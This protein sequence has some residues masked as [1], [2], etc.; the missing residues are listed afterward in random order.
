[1]TRRTPTLLPA[2]LLALCAAMAA[3]ASAFAADA[4]AASPSLLPRAVSV[5]AMPGRL[6]LA[7]NTHFVAREPRA[8]QV[9]AQLVRL[10]GD[11]C[12]IPRCV[13]RVPAP[14]WN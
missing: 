12:R 5:Q 8:K 13:R 7:G 14:P 1:M 9:L 2:G 3:P 11:A 10:A 4:A 6:V